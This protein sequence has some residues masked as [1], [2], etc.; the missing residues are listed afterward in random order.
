MEFVY[1][2]SPE[3][4]EGSEKYMETAGERAIIVKIPIDEISGKGRKNN[5]YKRVM[6]ME[7][8]KNP[9][10]IY[11]HIPFCIEKCSYCGFLS[12]SNIEEKVQ[13]DYVNK[14]I[15]EI[16]HYG[17]V[18]NNKSYVDSIFVGGGTPSLIDETLIASIS[19]IKVNF[20][21]VDDTEITI[22]ANPR[23]LTF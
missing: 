13:K 7:E 23:T 21:V 22:E 17:G 20:I 14:L 16:N 1:K 12:F 9:L 19:A 2:Y 5:I 15:E 8:N 6:I 4:V 11:V 10:G 3:Y 18:Y